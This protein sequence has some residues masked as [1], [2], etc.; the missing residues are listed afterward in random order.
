VVCRAEQRR[1][2]ELYPIRLRD[3]LPRV[4]IPLLLRDQAVLDLQALLAETWHKSGL[5]RRIDY[6]K[7]PVPPL[8]AAYDQWARELL[9]A[10]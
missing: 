10:R 6:T 8:A 5:G 9:A 3:R 2:R 1:Q 4:A 7:P